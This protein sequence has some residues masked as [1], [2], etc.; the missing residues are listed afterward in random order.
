LTH[1]LLAEASERLTPLPAA[2]NRLT[3]MLGD[4]DI[5]LRAV[6]DI[7]THDPALTAV[8]LRQANSAY[9]GFVRPTST[10]N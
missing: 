4:D 10:V 8:L 3:T 5:D 2:A 1:D 9:A 7:A 6:V